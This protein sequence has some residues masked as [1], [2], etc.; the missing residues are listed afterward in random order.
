MPPCREAWRVW[1]GESLKRATSLEV[2]ASISPPLSHRRRSRR[3]VL[4]GGAGSCPRTAPSPVF[5]SRRRRWG[6]DERRPC[7]L[8]D[9]QCSTTW[10][11]ART[12]TTCFAVP[13]WVLSTIPVILLAHGLRAPRA[14]PGGAVDRPAL[15]G[16]D[17]GRHARMQGRL[18]LLEPQD[19]NCRSFAGV[20]IRSDARPALGVTSSSSP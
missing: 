20:A 16:R 14:C 15:E 18:A 13:P 5:L 11:L 7:D 9:N 3:N 8:A 19:G 6:G 4:A 2:P 10:R 1:Q 17:A 12:S